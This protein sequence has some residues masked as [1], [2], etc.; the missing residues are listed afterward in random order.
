MSLKEVHIFTR[1]GVNNNLK[2]QQEE[3]TPKVPATLRDWGLRNKQLLL[4]IDPKEEVCLDK[5]QVFIK[6]ECQEKIEGYGKEGKNEKLNQQKK[7]Y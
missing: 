3:M 1:I 2:Q 7:K 6:A 4:E 5:N